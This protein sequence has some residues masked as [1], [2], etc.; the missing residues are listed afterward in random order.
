MGGSP[1]GPVLP[2]VLGLVG[3]VEEQGAISPAWWRGEGAGLQAGTGGGPLIS[4]ASSV[5]PLVTW[6]L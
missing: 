6:R 5:C 4:Q 2:V 1:A 3:P